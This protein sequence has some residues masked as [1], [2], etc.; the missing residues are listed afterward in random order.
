M[1][2]KHLIPLCRTYIFLSPDVWAA[3]PSIYG[4]AV[5]VNSLLLG[6]CKSLGMGPLSPF[7]CLSSHGAQRRTAEDPYPSC[8]AGMLLGCCRDEGSHGTANKSSETWLRCWLSPR[9]DGEN[10]CLFGS[11]SPRAR[12]GGSHPA[13]LPPARG[14]APVSLPRGCRTTG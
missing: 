13:A 11:A 4:S 14:R 5:W 8:S 7:P 3:E 12:S 10:S 6:E 9:R 2:H 1:A